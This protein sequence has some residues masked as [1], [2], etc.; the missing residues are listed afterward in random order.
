MLLPVL[1]IVKNDAWGAK[2]IT[3]QNVSI[4]NT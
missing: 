1:C 2:G 3:A 4:I